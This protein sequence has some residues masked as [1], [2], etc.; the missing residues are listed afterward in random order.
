ML[1]FQYCER[2]SV[3][4]PQINWKENSRVKIGRAIFVQSEDHKRI[5]PPRMMNYAKKIL[6]R[7]QFIYTVDWAR[8]HYFIAEAGLEI[9]RKVYTIVQKGRPTFPLQWRVYNLFRQQCQRSRSYY[10]YKEI[11]DGESSN[12][13][14]TWAKCKGLNLLVRNTETNFGRQ[15]LSH[16][17]EPV[18]TSR[19]RCK[20]CQ[21]RWKR[22][23]FAKTT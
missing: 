23:L 14:T 9:V 16:Q 15:S 3:Q 4:N 11:E 7:V 5:I 6:T 21:R 2:R 8:D 17:N 10:R 1:Y 13:L 12:S 19:M 22:E 20:S 18:S